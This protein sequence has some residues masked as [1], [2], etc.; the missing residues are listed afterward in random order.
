MLKVG[1]RIDS[2]FGKGTIR[3]VYS[4]PWKHIGG[5][6]IWFY[7]IDLD[8]ISCPAIT[9]AGYLWN[10]PIKSKLLFV[11]SWKEIKM[12]SGNIFADMVDQDRERKTDKE[13]EDKEMNELGEAEMQ[14]DQRA[15][16]IREE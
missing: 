9:N 14:N 12:Y 1:D 2:I 8:S 3:E 13:A 7:G 16:M 11:K 6:L 10:V 4:R 15:L 5:R